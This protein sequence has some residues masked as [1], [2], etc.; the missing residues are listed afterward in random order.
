VALSASSTLA[1]I[2]QQYVANAG[3]AAAGSASMAADFIE[4]ATALLVMLPTTAESGQ[5]TVGF[6]V[7]SVEKAIQRA[8]QWHAANRAASSAGL[9]VFDLS[10]V[11][12]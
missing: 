7:A 9:R 1:E 2:R 11:R 5:K 4:A 8:Q 6:S 3:Y 10:G 12:D